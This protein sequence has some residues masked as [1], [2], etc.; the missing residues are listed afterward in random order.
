VRSADRRQA[1]S[2]KKRHAVRLALVPAVDKP[3]AALST[4]PVLA[5]L[6]AS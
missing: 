3:H 6:Q 2:Y 4:L 1:G 5:F